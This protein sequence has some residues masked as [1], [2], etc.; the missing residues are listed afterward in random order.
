MSRRL[1]LPNAKA[2]V[3]AESKLTQYLLS[4]T[5]P[6]GRAKAAYF[7]SL[8]F[9]SNRIEELRSAFLSLATTNAES[10]ESTEFGDKYLVKGSITGP[11]GR[12]AAILT[13]WIVLHGS[14]TPILVTAYPES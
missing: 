1:K 13:I 7:F 12:T 5:H 2:A 8:G 14:D 11:N 3:V 9:E 10:M 6:V 4:S